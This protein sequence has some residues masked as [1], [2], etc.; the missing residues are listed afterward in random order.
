MATFLVKD[1][2]VPLSEYASVSEKATLFEA[3]LALE[4]AQ[5]KYTQSKY[6]HRAV[7]ILNEQKR[8]VG[9]LSQFDVIRALEPKDKLLDAFTD[10]RQF[11]FSSGFIEFQRRQ[12]QNGSASLEGILPQTAKLK[13][14]NFMQ[15]LSEGEYLDE[16]ASLELAIH[17]LLLG[18]HLALLVTRKG[19]ITGILRLSDV[20]AVVFQAMK[21]LETVKQT[22]EKE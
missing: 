5:E 14:V 16:N 21:E 10:I 20:F 17:Q 6:K 13:A 18:P 7:L 4:K 9:K 2:M 1:L 8:V 15:S 11:G 12:F 19:E 3:A 22:K